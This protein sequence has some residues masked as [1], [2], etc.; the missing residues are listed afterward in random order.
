MFFFSLKMWKKEIRLGSR[1]LTRDRKM[2]WKYISKHKA[3]LVWFNIIQRS[4]TGSFLWHFNC[5]SL[6]VLTY[7]ADW[8]SL[9]SKIESPLSRLTCWS[10]ARWWYHRLGI[11]GLCWLD[12]KA[13]PDLII[14]HSQVPSFVEAWWRR[15]R[16]AGG[17]KGRDR[18]GWRW[19]LT[20]HTVHSGLQ[21]N[22]SSFHFTIYASGK[23][24]N[25][26]S[27][28]LVQKTAPLLRSSTGILRK[29]S[30]K[31]RY[32]PANMGMILGKT[33]PRFCK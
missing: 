2:L 30:S 4:L 8:L 26:E 29:T 17:Q 23:Y 31:I 6:A 25:S 28:P 11:S 16:D 12:S 18:D 21:A 20:D 22:R 9:L 15:G 14:S 1:N 32:A 13:S 5:S 7:K 19:L 27:N 33:L 24:C 10:E 3:V